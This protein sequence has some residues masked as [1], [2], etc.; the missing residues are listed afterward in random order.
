MRRARAPHRSGR[1]RKPPRITLAGYEAPTPERARHAIAG[2]M[3]LVVE[4][5]RTDRGEETQL[6]RQRIVS[7]LEQLWK[8]GVLDAGQ[9]GAARCYQGDADLAAVTG[10]ASA[11]RY[12]PRW[13]EGGSERELLPAEAA[14]DHLARL[15]WAQVACGPTC[16]PM[17]DWI[18]IEPI[19]WRWQARAWWPEASER[20]ARREFH[21][22][23]RIACNGL[24]RHYRRHKGRR[25][26]T[27]ASD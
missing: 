27:S 3:E 19:G 22:L 9:Y 17:L 23:L 6:R 11:V 26:C 16:R 2:E 14:A 25:P 24:E 13:I 12:T 18:A 5:Y 10:P 8:A 1:K 4:A 21:R 7:P 20:W 15:A